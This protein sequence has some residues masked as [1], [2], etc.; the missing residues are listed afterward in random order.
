MNFEKRVLIRRQEE[1]GLAFSLK[2]K[3]MLAISEIDN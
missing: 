1:P 3:K 2:A